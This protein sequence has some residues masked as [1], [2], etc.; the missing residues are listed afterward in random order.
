[1]NRKRFSL[2]VTLA[3]LTAL[4]LTACTQPQPIAPAAPAASGETAAAGDAAAA[5]APAEIA[6]GGVWTR[7]LGADASNLN[8]ILYDDSSSNEVLSL[9]TVGLIGTDPVTGAFTPDG[10]MSES[11]TVSED[12]LTY[13]FKLRDGV[14]WSDGDPVDSA[15]FKFSYDAVNSDKV[16]SPR[17]Y[18]WD[19][20]ESIEAPDPL[21]VVVKFKQVKC[22]ALGDVGLGWLPSHLYGTD[23]SDIME[24]PDNSAPRVSSGPFTFQSWTRDDNVILVR[25]EGYWE[26]SP[27]M[28]GMIYKVVPD[29]GS[30]LA[31]LQSGEV[32][33]APL[34]P[35]QLSAIEGDANVTRYSWLDDGY[36]YI[37]LNMGNPANPQ[38]GRDESGNLI[39][40]EPHP[41][42]GD[43]R[44]R[45][46]IAHALD[47]DSIID[48]I[49]L[50][51]GY[52][53]A[54]NV[55]P[56]IDWAYDDSIQPYAYDLDAANALLE[57]AGWVDSNGDGV[58]EKDGKDLTLSLVTNSSNTTRMDLGAYVQDQ[59][60]SIG[61]KIDFQ[62]IDF[63]TLLEQMD[64]QSFDM[65]ILGWTGLGSDP[66]D[67]PF[68]SSEDDVPGSGFNSVSYQNA[69][70]DELLVKGYSVPGC[71]P[72]DRAPIY[73][74]IQKIIHDEVPY[75][76][77]TG[78]RG[79]IGYRSRWGGLDPQPW[80]T[81]YNVHKWYLKELQP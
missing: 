22:D 41:V 66:N 73:K 31:Q 27:Y 81:Y 69:K 61:F 38:P 53:L 72:E 49:Y 1:M 3:L 15:D 62:G 40:Q 74:E 26:G 80:A 47:Y 71:K 70:I 33:I 75:I 68:W 23:F 39:P 10:S 9:L 35:S 60:D 2:I 45:Q 21:T 30:R 51:Q 25:N 55:L 17:K 76:F 32:D 57:E 12:G 58:R 79:N 54:A 65:F 43:V 14:V 78:T 64:A 59:L 7:I 5:A 36:S 42:L 37:G 50:G 29:A 48:N 11:W 19:G 67:K 20:I 18:V 34:Q 4:V 13:T 28:D 16:E 77:V 24:S 8:P 44:V 52:R 6:N 46:A 56:A 63:G